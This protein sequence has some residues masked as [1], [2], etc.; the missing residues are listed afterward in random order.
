MDLTVIIF[1]IFRADLILRVF[2]NDPSDIYLTVQPI[3][4]VGTI[5]TGLECIT[6]QFFQVNIIQLAC[7]QPVNYFAMFIILIYIL[8][9]VQRICIQISMKVIENVSHNYRNIG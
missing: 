2:F 7:Y 5:K 6:V 3:K 4:F 8:A 1:S 9:N